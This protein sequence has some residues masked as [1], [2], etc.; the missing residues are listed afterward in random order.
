[1]ENIDSVIEKKINKQIKS[2][3]EVLPFSHLHV[4][5]QSSIL[6]ATGSI[7]ALIEIVRR[8]RTW[9]DEAARKELLRLFEV[10]GANDENTLS[11]RRQLSSLLFS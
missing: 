8:D 9:N 7:D 5:S 1:M 6:Q 11:G 3:L 2:E 10:F 4:H